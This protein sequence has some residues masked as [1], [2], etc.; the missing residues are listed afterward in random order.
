MR[1]LAFSDLHRDVRQAR[2]LAGM[3]AEADVVLAAGDF[4]SIHHG[5]DETLAPLREIGTPTLVVPGNNE[6]EA[7]LRDACADWS[8]ATVLHGGGTEIDGTVFWGLGAGVPVTPWDWSF[9][10]DEQRAAEM[11]AHCP[12]GAVLVVHSAPK[13]HVDNGLGSEA[14]LRA[15][16]RVRPPLAVCGHIHECW[17]QES[18]AG[19][20]RIVNVGPAGS[21][22]EL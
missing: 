7:A 2:R 6:T 8:A 19:T 12:E 3:A 18:S 5:L 10:L 21:V 15:I 20:S 9:D 11:L 13:G 22:L 17:G 4:A 14:I 16:E 1:L